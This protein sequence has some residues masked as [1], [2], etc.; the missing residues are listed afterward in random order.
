MKCFHIDR[1]AQAAFAAFAVLGILAVSPTTEAVAQG[2]QTDHIVLVLKKDVGGVTMCA[3][4]PDTLRVTKKG[5]QLRI[6][7]VAMTPNVKV[8]Q[9]DQKPG[10]RNG[11]T[12]IVEVE[13]KTEGGR[14]VRRIKRDKDGQKLSDRG[15]LEVVKQGDMGILKLNSKASGTY[16]Y[17]VE[18]GNTGDDPPAIIVD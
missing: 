4:T 12:G 5:R 18:C 13:I 16:Q 9:L 8:T 10:L 17:E 11:N 14:K 7:F 1:A 6:G 15:T 3:T 2:N